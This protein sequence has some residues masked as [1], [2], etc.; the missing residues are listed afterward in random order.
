[1]IKPTDNPK[2]IKISGPINESYNFSISEELI[3]ETSYLKMDS[4]CYDIR[5]LPFS[6]NIIMS[7]EKYFIDKSKLI[8]WI[9]TNPVEIFK[10]DLDVIHYRNSCL[11]IINLKKSNKNY[12][13]EKFHQAL[14]E[15]N[16]LLMV[17]K[18]N[19]KLYLTITFFNHILNYLGLCN[20]TFIPISLELSFSF[21]ADFKFIKDTVKKINFEN[22]LKKIELTR[23]DYEQKIILNKEISVQKN[24]DKIIRL[25][26]NIKD[27]I[28]DLTYINFDTHIPLPIL[29]IITNPL[30]SDLYEYFELVYLLSKKKIN[31]N[32][33]PGILET[34]DSKFVC[35]IESIYSRI[36]AR[37]KN[38]NRIG[39]VH[40]YKYFIDKKCDCSMIHNLKSNELIDEIKFIA[41]LNYHG[42]SPMCSNFYENN[43]DCSEFESVDPVVDEPIDDD[44]VIWNEFSSEEDADI[45]F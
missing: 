42:C 21:G 8:D 32:I 3:P 43:W 45:Y 5:K 33:I 27:R 40:F 38:K 12:F 14:K 34:W 19:G 11:E 41:T 1:M 22:K 7:L 9:I 35:L 23:K 2:Q 20:T 44:F 15:K 39:F 29:I 13:S 30:I 25:Q 26:H 24:T 18:I 36:L 4:E 28:K 6:D 31:I 10:S 37:S 17:P 16:N